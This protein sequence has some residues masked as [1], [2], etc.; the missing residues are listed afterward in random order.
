MP[1][2]FHARTVIE[3]ADAQAAVDGYGGQFDRFED[4]FEALKWLLAHKCDGLPSLRRGVGG[5]D[6]ILY[7]QAGDIIAGTPNITV[8]YTFDDDEVTILHVRAEER[9]D[10]TD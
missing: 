2:W 1:V 8:V 6:Y 4:A 7:K 3:S 10:L 5:I 9:E